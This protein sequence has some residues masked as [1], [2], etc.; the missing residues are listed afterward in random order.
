VVAILLLLVT[1]IATNLAGLYE[2][3]SLNA[4]LGARTGILGGLGT[5]A[6]A[7]FIATPCTGPFM[8]GA[9]GAA[10]LLPVPAA[11]AV[12]AGLG[13]GLSLPFLALGFIKPARRWLPRPG[14]WM[15]TVRRVLSLP[16]FVTALGLAWIVG[17][18]AGVSAMTTALAAALL[19][20][21]ALWWYGLR[22]VSDRI[23]FPTAIPAVAAIAL[24]FWGTQAGSATEQASHLLASK[25]YTAA[26]LAEL[27][28][29]H[30]PVFVFLTADWC[31]SCKVN[32]AT[33]LSSASVA[34][35]FAKAH[36]AVLEGDWTRGNPEVT[37][38]L[39]QQG[40]AGVPLY[41][42]YPKN[43]G[44]SRQLPQVLTPSMLV[45]L[46]TGQSSS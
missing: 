11:L 27:R 9:L 34:D 24:A 28:A 43:G 40:R 17:R 14:P 23:A 32:E 12:F 5:G 19:L 26:R 33:S 16:M 38:L 41:I 35:A 39:T 1:A 31:L 21:V 25:P 22:Q 45:D 13:L 30:R 18:Q 20:G 10:M 46:T 29:D 8:A 6:L 4:D 2:L 15:M 42:W 7:A 44:P 3:P 37:Q 36:V